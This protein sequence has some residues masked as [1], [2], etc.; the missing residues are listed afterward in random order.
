M[1][2]V[3][4][5]IAIAVLL[6]A[7]A[8]WKLRILEPLLWRTFLAAG[9]A[10]AI[11]KP[12]IKFRPK[13]LPGPL[14]NRG[15]KIPELIGGPVDKAAVAIRISKSQYKLTVLYKSKP[16]KEYPI[17]LG[18]DPVAYKIREGDKRTPEGLFK[19]R[20]LYPNRYWSKFI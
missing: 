12:F 11:S 3:L 16:V 15:V 13:G 17:V 20:G 6:A 19:V 18:S 2:K 10:K 4:L 9:P 8:L 1:R 14:L 7:A 5:I